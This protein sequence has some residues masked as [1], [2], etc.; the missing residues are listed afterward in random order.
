M[1]IWI[2]IYL[3]NC[4]FKVSSKPFNL[5]YFSAQIKPLSL[6]LS[7]THIY[8]A[9]KT[10]PNLPAPSTRII[11]KSFKPSFFNFRK[12]ELVDTVSE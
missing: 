3:I 8:I 1:N 10:Y 9:R 12:E 4:F 2:F 5:I 7:F 11:K 6:C